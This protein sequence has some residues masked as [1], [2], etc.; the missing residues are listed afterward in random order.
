MKGETI[1]DS[2]VKKSKPKSKEYPAITLNKAIEFV[3]KFKD[4]PLGK[5][6]AYDVAAKELGVS[7]ATK[8]F[9]YSISSA[10]QFGLIATSTGQTFTLQEAAN[11][12]IRPTTEAETTIKAIKNKCFSTPQL[13]NKLIHEYDGKS[14]PSVG[15][16]ENVL[17]TY[18]QILPAVAKVAAQKFIDS[19]VELGIVQNGVLCLSVEVEEKDSKELTVNS[20]NDSSIDE[21][22]V[23]ATNVLLDTEMCE[24]AAP[25]NIP[26]GDKRKAVLYMPLDSKKE[27]AEYVRDMILLMFKRVYKVD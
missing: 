8:S 25:L 23:G 2:D 15:T 13:Y 18:H 1:M 11:F 3:K 14:L 7:S 17:V 19:A 20:V 9:R 21:N 27:D 10:K 5:P 12:L 24:F 4:Y 6:I 22:S 16:L 26:F